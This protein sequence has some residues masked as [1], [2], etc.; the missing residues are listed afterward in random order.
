[1]GTEVKNRKTKAYFKRYFWLYLFL[2]PALVYF[3]VFCYGPM[4]GILMAFQDFKP[5]RGIR[6]S[7]F[8]G[9]ENFRILFRSSQ[10]S[11]VLRNSVWISLIKLLWGFPVPILLAVVLS[12]LRMRKFVKVSQTVTYIPHFISWVVLSGIM[13]RLLST[14]GGAVNILIEALGG[15]PK[16]FLLE[17]E[18]FRSVLVISDIWKESGWSAI[19]YIAAISGIDRELF[20]AARVDGA[21]LLQKIRY[22]TLPGLASTI[23]V[24]LILRMGS[25]IRNGFEQIYMLYSAPV[26]DVADVFETYTYRIGMLQ[27]QYSYS[28]AVGLFQS[29]VGLLM[30]L[31][32]NKISQKI[33]EGGIW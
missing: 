18:Y 7:E 12:E 9:W 17:P 8:V 2:L 1:M 5:V 31:V 29:V 3:A 19:V 30:V 11:R 20:D 13:V 16:Q 24:V 26:F 15:T 10:F 14:S 23:T 22:V 33:G 4:Y 6:G 27:A 28:T 25:V 21:G 32:T